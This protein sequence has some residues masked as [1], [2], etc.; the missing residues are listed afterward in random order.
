MSGERRVSVGERLD[1][2]IVYH[3]TQNLRNDRR[4][5]S[6]GP[7]KVLTPSASGFF[8]GSP[9]LSLLLL[10]HLFPH[11]NPSA[12]Q[13]S[14]VTRTGNPRRRNRGPAKRTTPD[15]GP[16]GETQTS[17]LGGRRRSSQA[18]S[19]RLK[20]L[21]TREGSQAS[22]GQRGQGPAQPLRPE[23]RRLD[24]DVASITP[25]PGRRAGR[26]GDPARAAAAAALRS[27]PRGR[28]WSPAGGGRGPSLRPRRWGW[29]RA[30]PK[31]AGNLA[32]P[33]P[34]RHSRRPGL[35]TQTPHATPA[36]TSLPCRT[37]APLP[38]SGPLG[39]VG[40]G[41]REGETRRR[42]GNGSLRTG[43]SRGRVELGRRLIAKSFVDPVVPEG[44][45][46]RIAGGGSPGRVRTVVFTKSTVATGRRSHVA[47]LF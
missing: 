7:Q 5:T 4:R 22:S 3:V 40:S 29:R 23:S 44:G 24:L 14:A 43:R 11:R 13:R 45:P 39:G 38:G 9:R 27:G 17:D 46:S 42:R 21:Q 20:W 31:P 30:P 18:L 15:L 33:V 36:R 8:L 10:V 28:R 6:E 37:L 16:S 12:Y 19:Q 25:T 34:T 26:V 1:A 41:S 2:V 32:R 35:R 47:V